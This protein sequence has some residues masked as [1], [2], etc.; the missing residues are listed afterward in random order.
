MTRDELDAAVL[1]RIS[2]GPC[3]MA[4]LI[5]SSGVRKNLIN[6]SLQRL[7]KRNAISKARHNRNTNRYYIGE[8]APKEKDAV[9]EAR[10]VRVHAIPVKRVVVRPF[11][12]AGEDG[13]AFT[14]T[15]PAAPWEIRA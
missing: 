13:K 1:G 9:L 8:T 12:I 6:A 3:I 2:Q 11:S 10:P 7:F 4:D 15:L 5:A 14:V